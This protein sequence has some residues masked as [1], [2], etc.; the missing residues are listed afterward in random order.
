MHTENMQQR[1]LG[2]PSLNISIC[3]PLIFSFGLIARSN[4]AFGRPQQALRFEFL[5]LP[6][7]SEQTKYAA[8]AFAM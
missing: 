6:V 3:L 7:A 4:V 8:A 1:P 5:T 2:P